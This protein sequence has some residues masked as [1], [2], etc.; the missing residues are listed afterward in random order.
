MF[1]L[2]RIF[3]KLLVCEK[4]HQIQT[5]AENTMSYNRIQNES[6]DLRRVKQALLGALTEA[7]LK[8]EP[9]QTLTN[10]VKFQLQSAIEAQ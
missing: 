7:I 1:G 6:T 4:S 3:Q 5:T 9:S 8:I 2:A 10:L